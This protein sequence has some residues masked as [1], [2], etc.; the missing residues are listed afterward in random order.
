MFAWHTCMSLFLCR[1]R[2]EDQMRSWN[3]SNGHSAPRFP[4]EALVQQVLHVEACRMQKIKQ[5]C[6]PYQSPAQ[7]QWRLCHALFLKP[8]VLH[9]VHY[10]DVGSNPEADQSSDWRFSHADP[11]SNREI[12]EGEREIKH[13]PNAKSHPPATAEPEAQFNLPWHAG[14]N[15]ITWTSNLTLVFDIA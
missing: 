7:N 6:K 5:Q 9:G 13:T 3:F 14:S 2:G 10:S 1:E 8:S 11:T 4:S 15:S 12:G